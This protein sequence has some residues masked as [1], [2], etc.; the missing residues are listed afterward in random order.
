M[1]C[2]EYSADA[3][4]RP[5]RAASLWSSSPSLL[6]VPIQLARS[7]VVVTQAKGSGIALSVYAGL[8]MGEARALEVCDVD[9]KCDRILVRHAL[10]ADHIVPPSQG[11]NALSRWRP[12]SARSSKRRCDANCR[13]PACRERARRNAATSTRPRRAQAPRA[14]AGAAQV[15]LPLATPLLLHDADS[16]RCRHRGGTSASGHSKLDV[17][18]RYVHATADDLRARRS[19]VSRVTS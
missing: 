2:T 17:T 16:P 7:H 19:L 11:T 10:S 18:Q 14:K 12:S 5:F 15:V 13:T 4:T 6:D 3:S 8:H 9:F 1:T